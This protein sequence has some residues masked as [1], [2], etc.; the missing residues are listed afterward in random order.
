MLE[1]VDLSIIVPAFNHRKY[2][3]R[4]LE[5]LINQKTDYSYE[6]IVG[7]DCSTDG[8]REIIDEI[9]R[10]YPGLIRKK[11]HTQNLGATKNGYYMMR[12]ARGKYLAFCDGDDF[13]MDDNRIQRHVDF[14]EENIGYAGISSRI[15]LV[16]EDS[17]LLNESN[18]NENNQF[19]KCMKAE[20][21]LKDFEKWNMPGHVSAITIR[22]FMKYDDHDYSIFYRVHNMVG[23]RTIILFTVLHGNIRCETD[24]VSCYRYRT[25][26]E[27][28]FMS[29][30]KKQNMYG[31]DYNMLCA[32]EKYTK[33]EFDIKIDLSKVKKDRLVASVV[34]VM[35]EH[36]RSDIQILCDIIRQSGVPVMYCYYVIKII[37]LKK[38]YWKILKEDRIINL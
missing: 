1:D 27:N 32:L 14:L 17:N 38:Y 3:R 8:T 22:N 9:Q 5:S 10:M 21:T 16:D 30:F 18:I 35:K 11:Y 36:R 37:I 33:K 25:D 29:V 23:D 24:F 34:C 7:D 26:Q 19:W 15:K 13:W 12:A 31:Q 28:N 6:I 4:A 20:Y 2:I